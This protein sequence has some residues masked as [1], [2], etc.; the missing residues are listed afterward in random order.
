[1]KIN[2]KVAGVGPSK[3]HLLFN[4]SLHWAIL[5]V[6]KK[7]FFKWAITGICFLFR[8]LNTDLIQL[9]VNKIC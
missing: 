8:R 6:V 4:F 2:K 7:V 5:C 3:N 9:I 1:M